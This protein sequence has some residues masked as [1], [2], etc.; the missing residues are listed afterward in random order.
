MNFDIVCH[1]N[2]NHIGKISRCAVDMTARRFDVMI[3]CHSGARTDLR[4]RG[5]C[6]TIA[7]AR[8][9]RGFAEASSVG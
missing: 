1:F 6:G 2:S 3:D 7:R 8:I 4:I 9:N 5:A